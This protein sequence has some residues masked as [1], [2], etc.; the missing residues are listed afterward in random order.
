MMGSSDGPLSQQEPLMAELSFAQDIK[1]LFRDKDRSSMRG[2]FDL[3]SFQDVR[4][5]APAILDVLRSGTMPCDGK[6]SP[7]HI[8]LFSRW[9][10]GGMAE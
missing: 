6:W 4:D 7:D 10:V 8:D 1:P 9:I 3:W 2:R 5:N